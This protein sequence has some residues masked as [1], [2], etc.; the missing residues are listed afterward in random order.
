M[1]TKIDFE[2]A[3]IAYKII[4]KR[5]EH[6]SLEPCS[7][8]YCESLN[9]LTQ[10]LLNL[11]QIEFK[12]T[13]KELKDYRPALAYAEDTLTKIQSL[14]NEYDQKN[15]SSLWSEIQSLL[16]KHDQRNTSSL[17]PDTFE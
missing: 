4:R 6:L 10:A 17:W 16:N 2:T 14:L 5:I 1:E 9:N 3:Q 15:T 8:E 11:S 12:N 13:S 7:K